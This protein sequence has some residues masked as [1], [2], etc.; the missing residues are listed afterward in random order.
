MRTLPAY[1]SYFACGS[2]SLFVNIL[3]LI[4][5]SMPSLVVSGLLLCLRDFCMP[6]PG[7]LYVSVLL[8]APDHTS[9]T[10][11]IS[12][13]SHLQEVLACLKELLRLEKGWLPNKEGYS[14]Y[15][16][17]FMFSSANTLGIGPPSRTTM[18][19][20]LSPCGPYF[21]TGME[22][23]EKPTHFRFERSCHL[24]PFTSDNL[25]CSQSTSLSRAPAELMGA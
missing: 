9:A 22:V 6:V 13:S 19:I 12:S 25:P 18:S 4:F 1:S 16:R 24:G 3:M 17:P 15:I 5:L 14:L 2:R 20:I 11:L 10:P 7:R 23:F 8:L 21:P